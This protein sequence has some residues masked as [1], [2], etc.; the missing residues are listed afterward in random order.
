MATSQQTTRAS[1]GDLSEGSAGGIDPAGTPQSTGKPHQVAESAVAPHAQA[2][3][4]D[5]ASHDRREPRPGSNPK[6][7]GDFGHR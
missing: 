7:P 2:Y 3:T 5:E 4:P 1:Q 6:N